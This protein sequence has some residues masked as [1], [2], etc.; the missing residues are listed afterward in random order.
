M[1]H[2]S[3]NNSKTKLAQEEGWHTVPFT[4]NRKSP[5]TKTNEA[6]GKNHDPGINVKLF[7]ATTGK[8]I[9]TQKLKYIPK[10]ITNQFN[11]IP[12]PDH[13]PKIFSNQSDESHI[14][15][16]TRFSA[17]NLDTQQMILDNTTCG[18][19]QNATNTFVHEPATKDKFC[20][21]HSKTTKRQNNSYPKANP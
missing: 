8:Y 5:P 21:K 1:D 7:N 3:I 11:S 10:I 17:I 19:N 16:K 6:A 14:D 12:I 18:N 4:R 15:T 9:V 20:P 2:S 13:T